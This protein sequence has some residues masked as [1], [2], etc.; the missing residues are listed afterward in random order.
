M[1]RENARS[2]EITILEKI[3]PQ[4]LSESSTYQLFLSS[5]KLGNGKNFQGIQTEYVVKTTFRKHQF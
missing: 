3:S 2:T 4:G 1:Y 5:Q